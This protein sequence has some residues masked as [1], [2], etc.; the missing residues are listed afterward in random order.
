MIDIQKWYEYPSIDETEIISSRVRLARN[1]AKYP[2]CLRLNN[3]S[4]RNIIADAKSSLMGLNPYPGLVLC[5]IDLY[6]KTFGELK[7]LSEKHT[8]S[9]VMVNKSS[10]R[11]LLHNEEENLSIMLNEE[12]HVR[13]QSIFVGQDLEKAYNHAAKIDDLMSENLEFA[14][15]PEF[16]YLT[17]C[18]TNTGTGLRA[19]YM[20]HL[21][22]LEHTGNLKVY[23]DFIAKAGFAIRGAHGEGSEPMGS[24]YQVSNQITLGKSEEETISA[25]KHLAVQIIEKETQLRERILSEYYKETEDTVWRA[26]GIL[27]NCRKLSL[28]EGMKLLSDFRCGRIMGILQKQ[29]NTGTIYNLMLNIQPHNLQRIMGKAV[30]IRH[31]DALRA[32]YVRSAMR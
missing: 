29:I 27:E 9:P 17:S 4:A 32:D 24:L 26:C 28:R 6:E 31:E 10:L 2:F 13:I 19:S 22:V 20:L 11:A 7:E 12:D 1:L 16:G 14:F 8:I 25:L 3:E 21:P 30:D 5:Y 15:D 23:A 18:P